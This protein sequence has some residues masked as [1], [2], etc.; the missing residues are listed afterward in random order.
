MNA[1]KRVLCAMLTIALLASV[2]SVNA[3]AAGESM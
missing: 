2:I 3:F 1:L